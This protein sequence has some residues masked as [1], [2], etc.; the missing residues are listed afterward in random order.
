MNQ[1][2]KKF[3]LVYFVM[4]LDFGPCPSVYFGLTERKPKLTEVALVHITQS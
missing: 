1:G 2:K 3:G 4:T